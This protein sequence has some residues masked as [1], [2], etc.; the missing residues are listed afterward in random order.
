[1]K[2]GHR[3]FLVVFAVVINLCSIFPGS[4]LAQAAVS[5]GVIFGSVK[6][7]SGDVIT[8]VTI[9]LYNPQGE[10]ISETSV[11]EAG[12]YAFSGL[13]AGEYYLATYNIAGYVDE[14]YPDE[15]CG[16]PCYTSSPYPKYSYRNL[17]GYQLFGSPVEV[18]S[19]DSVEADFVLAKAAM[20]E[21]KV[22]D[23][24]TG[25]PLVSWGVDI[26]DLAGER[27]E[28]VMSD[29]NGVYQS[30][31]NLPGGDYFLHTY[32]L[33]QGQ[34]YI[35]ETHEGDV[36]YSRC[37]SGIGG[38]RTPIALANGEIASSVDFALARAG[39]ISGR[40]TSAATE[41]P[42]RNARVIF[43]SNNIMSVL[44]RSDSNGDYEAYFDGASE[45]LR[46]VV[47]HDEYIS[48]C[49]GGL[50]C[51]Q[52][53]EL[54]LASGGSIAN[55][56]IA[57][58]K[59]GRI[60]G[61]VVSRDGGMP[62]SD[63]K[64]EI[65]SESGDEVDSITDAQGN[66]ISG[67]TLEAGRYY[68]CTDGDGAYLNECVGGFFDGDLRSAVSITQ[69]ETTRM[70]FAL[71]LGGSIAGRVVDVDTGGGVG[72]A[73]VNVLDENGRII[74]YV[75]SNSDGE[76]ETTRGLVSGRYRVTTEVAGGC[77]RDTE[78]ED[79]GRTITVVEGERTDGVDIQLRVPRVPQLVS[80]G[81]IYGY[82]K[83]SVT[84]EPLPGMSVAPYT[85]EFNGDY[86]LSGTDAMGRFIIAGLNAGSYFLNSYNTRG[87]FDLPDKQGDCEGI[88]ST[89][90]L[91]PLTI[92]AEKKSVYA[93]LLFERG[94][95]IVG[96]VTD[97]A[98]G[99][100][101]GGGGGTYII[102]LDAQYNNVSAAEVSSNGWYRTYGGLAPG[103]YILLVWSYG[104]FISEYYLD[105]PVAGS[106]GGAQATPLTISELQSD[107]DV[108]ADFQ[109]DKGA[110]IRG[111]VKDAT[112]GRYLDNVLIHIYDS[113]GFAVSY[114]WTAFGGGVSG[115][116]SYFTIF[117]LPEG[118]YYLIAS[119][120]GDDEA[121]VYGGETFS[122]DLC[123]VRNGLCSTD[124]SVIKSPP[125][126]V[127]GVDDLLNIDFELGSSNVA[128]EEAGAASSSGGGV[129]YGLLV[130]LIVCWMGRFRVGFTR[131]G[132]N[133]PPRPL[134]N[135][136]R[137]Q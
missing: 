91:A 4:S 132:L 2:N 104:G 65:I 117:G 40:I 67:S 79:N 44:T 113:D 100:W 133:H 63:I 101:G 1:M 61:R 118:R 53:A 107:S 30:T 73:I 34:G 116:G 93:E 36:C 124:V 12:G 90:E 26:F 19:S 129:V 71:A 42:I 85:A 9:Y 15:V 89:L 122:G 20:I 137:W 54:V 95:R 102:V 131:A 112:T 25:A 56:D 127:S 60:S 135:M 37:E 130:I 17:N 14:I 109:L 70:D 24:A 82:I 106:Q 59:G 49:Y 11:N 86:Y 98:N 47:E 78:C 32:E 33:W 58:R 22:V 46:V 123:V 84:G 3:F 66:Y 76:Y 43:Y 41:A 87:Y 13:A 125:V 121:T 108:V 126:V 35:D 120:G 16:R 105:V 38:E 69:A 6:N 50:F 92:S 103:S 52:G 77:G 99:K 83:D 23:E 62:L 136:L 57:L 128:A 29:R 97:S 21:G 7:V 55:V 64:I 114:G 96:R 10:N 119:A 94:A 111:K 74:E 48:G 51:S 68:V 31:V 18:I 8:G 75:Y 110:K 134:G 27:V 80:G 5:S 115:V 45:S 28:S 81:V 39:K 72:R 88:C